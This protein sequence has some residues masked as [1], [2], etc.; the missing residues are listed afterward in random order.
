MSPRA[1]SP[2]NA[3]RCLVLLALS[4]ASDVLHS[5]L[6]RRLLPDA[7]LL[8]ASLGAQADPQTV[9]SFWNH[10]V[11]SEAVAPGSGKLLE[12]RACLVGPQR[13]GGGFAG[14]VER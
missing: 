11:F 7:A 14:G 12:P 10:G 13:G 6:K 3:V 5:P 9:R 2:G 1:P 4:K 8:R